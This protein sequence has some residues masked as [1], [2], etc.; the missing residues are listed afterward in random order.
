MQRSRDLGFGR[1]CSTKDE[2]ICF[3]SYV[4]VWVESFW[5]TEKEC[6][7]KDSVSRVSAEEALSCVMSLSKLL[8]AARV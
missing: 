4:S 5:L 1:L 2:F 6:I 7:E 8:W 3:F